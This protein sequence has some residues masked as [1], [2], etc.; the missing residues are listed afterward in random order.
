MISLLVSAVT[1]LFV[2]V[3]L[4]GVRI[5]RLE[6]AADATIECFEMV[7]KRGDIA[8]EQREALYQRADKADRRDIA[9]SRLDILRADFDDA[10]DRAGS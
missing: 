1:V 8:T 6:K 2:L 3:I 4:A 9:I 7:E 10:D 5:R